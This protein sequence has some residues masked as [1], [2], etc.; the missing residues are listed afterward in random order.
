MRI[1]E[2]RIAENTE[3]SCISLSFNPSMYNMWG[4]APCL[5]VLK[6]NGHLWCV[7]YNSNQ[8]YCIVSLLTVWV[9]YEIIADT[10]Q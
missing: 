4:Q 2:K 6:E 9:K 7:K 5:D 10:N 1:Q 3:A 8:L